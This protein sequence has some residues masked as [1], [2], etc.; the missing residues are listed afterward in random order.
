MGLNTA[1]TNIALKLITQ[2]GRDA[3]LNTTTEGAYDPTSIALGKTVVQSTIKVYE[4]TYKTRDI[5]DGLIEIGDAP[6]YT[7]SAIDKDDTVEYDSKK[8]AIISVTKYGVNE[9]TVLHVANVRAL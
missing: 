6:L 7:I 4:G 8:Y 1:L 9:S 2:F 5:K 3:T